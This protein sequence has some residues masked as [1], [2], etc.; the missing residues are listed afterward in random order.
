MLRRRVLVVA[1]TSCRPDL[2]HQCQYVDLSCLYPCITDLQMQKY[3]QGIS[4]VTWGLDIVRTSDNHQRTT[5]CRD[6]KRHAKMERRATETPDCG[7]SRR[8]LRSKKVI[9]RIELRQVSRSNMMWRLYAP[10]ENLGG[11]SNRKTCRFPIA[12]LVCFY[13]DH[14]QDPALRRALLLLVKN[15]VSSVMPCV[16][17]LGTVIDLVYYA[18]QESATPQLSE[19]PNACVTS[20]YT[21]YS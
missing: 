1:Q 16:L 20:L 17:F 6:C 9:L 18:Y 10:T 14:P 8:L 5:F 19:V 3:Q 13:S 2:Q 7:T 12:K 4:K 11:P 15:R 21:S